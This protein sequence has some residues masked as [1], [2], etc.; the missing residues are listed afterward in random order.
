MTTPNNTKPDATSLTKDIETPPHASRQKEPPLDAHRIRQITDGLGDIA[1]RIHSASA[2]KKGPLYE[3]L[4][5]TITYEHETRTAT[6]R[7]RP[8]NPYRQWLCPRADSTTDDT[9]VIAQERLGEQYPTSTASTGGLSTG[10]SPRTMRPFPLLRSHALAM[11]DVMVR[12]L[13][14]ETTISWRDPTSP[15]EVRITRCNNGRKRPLTHHGIQTKLQAIRDFEKAQPNEP[16][17]VTVDPAQIKGDPSAL[18]QLNPTRGHPRGNSPWVRACRNSVTPPGKIC[19][20]GHCRNETAT[21]QSKLSPDGGT[22]R[23]TSPLKS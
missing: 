16:N 20:S 17:S 22:S 8:S 5:I 3:A 23:Q 11:I 6:V 9:A 4:G 14:D 21:A 12:G 19:T 10:A 15:D 1:Q 13:T 18:A 2:D 7:S